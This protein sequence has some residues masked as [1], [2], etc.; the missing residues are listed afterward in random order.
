M[1]ND[2]KCPN[3]QGELE[4][5][6]GNTY[7][8]CKGC[9]SLFMHNN[10][11]LTPYPVDEANRAMIEQALGFTPSTTTQVKAEPPKACPVCNASLEVVEKDNEILTRCTSCGTLSKVQGPGGLIP[12]I[13]TPPGG[14]WD[15]KFQA[16]FEQELGFTYKERKKPIGI[17]E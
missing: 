3:C 2:L 7:A 8:R 14:G 9:K 4:F 6:G 15:P 5:A 17:P 11:A 16:I 13:V 1:M 12:I 10:N